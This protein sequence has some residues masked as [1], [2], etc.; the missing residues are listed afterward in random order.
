MVLE[1]LAP[2]NQPAQTIY[3]T[4]DIGKQLRDLSY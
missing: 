2:P 1:G 4:V 3:E